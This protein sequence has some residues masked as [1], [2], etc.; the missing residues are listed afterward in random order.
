MNWLIIINTLLATVFNIWEK[1][2]Q[3]EGDEALPDW[4]MIASKNMMLQKKIDAEKPVV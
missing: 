3:I 4:D 1:V 2:R